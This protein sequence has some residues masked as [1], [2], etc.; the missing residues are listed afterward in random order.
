[1][2]IHIIEPVNDIPKCSYIKSN[3]YFAKYN[4]IQKKYIEYIKSKGQDPDNI[5]YRWYPYLTTEKPTYPEGSKPVSYYE[6]CTIVKGNAYSLVKSRNVYL[7]LLNKKPNVPIQS[8]KIK[9]YNIIYCNKTNKYIID[10]V[11]KA[12][13]EEEHHKRVEAKKQLTL[14][15]NIIKKEE[16]D[17]QK[18]LIK[19]EIKMK[20]NYKEPCLLCGM[21]KYRTTLE[22]HQKT[23]RCRTINKFLVD[24]N[25][26]IHDIM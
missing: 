18:Q 11:V 20:K 23:L 26:N 8:D 10:P 12:Q 5:V 22:K 24:N 3:D 13:E 19:A 21:N 2:S 16:E 15:A 6:M 14:E 25:K 4:H 7:N 17:K 9:D 1:M